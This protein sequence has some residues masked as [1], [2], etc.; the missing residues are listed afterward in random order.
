MEPIRATFDRLRRAQRKAVIPFFVGG[1]P[2]GATIASLLLR[3]EDAGADLI[4]VGI[5]FSDP[6]ADG[7]VIQAA[8]ARALA[9]GATPERVLAAIASVRHRLQA[10]VIC[11]SYWNPLLQF[12]QRP[13]GQR[14]SS[15]HPDPAPFV[16][17][18]Q[19]SGVA[20]MFVP[21]LPLEES[22]TLRRSARRA[23][24]ATILLA[25]PTSPLER[26]RA[27]ARAS[28]GF[29]YSVSV[30]GTTGIRKHLPDGLVE[31]VRRLKRLTTTPV[32][33]GFG[34]S[35]P[36]Q[37]AQVA[38]MDGADGVIVGSAL[39]HTLSNGKSRAAGIRQAERLITRLR[40]AIS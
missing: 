16:R 12:G 22:A 7:P 9:H 25:A 33:V 38:A 10:P 29:I 32:C 37:A 30:I 13:S 14:T 31:G 18:A 11:L 27:S 8:S 1:D 28:E 26:L 24:P 3:F 6:L 36:A 21:D 40:R 2:D 35:T 15:I 19:A 23:G 17:A 20:G 39:V 5:P 4:E 34:I